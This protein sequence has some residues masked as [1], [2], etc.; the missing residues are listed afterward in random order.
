MSHQRLTI[1][2]LVFFAAL[3][4]PLGLLA[5]RAWQGLGAEEQA[6]VRFSAESLMDG[7]QGELADLVQALEDLPV[8]QYA[9]PPGEGLQRPYVLGLLQ[10]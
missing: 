3:A 1:F 8:D 4:A 9:E 6:R 2:I 7:I 10:G 5:N